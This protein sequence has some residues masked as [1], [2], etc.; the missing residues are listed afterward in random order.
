M[1]KTDGTSVSVCA[2]VY[3]GFVD[4]SA[5]VCIRDIS[6][7]GLSFYASES[8]VPDNQQITIAFT[9]A[10]D[11]KQYDV[12]VECAV[13]RVSS[14]NG[15]NVIGCRVVGDNRTYQL[16]EFMKR[17]AVERLGTG[18][19]AHFGERDKSGVA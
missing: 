6:A 5:E 11:D 1:Q 9:D 12:R 14:E 3:D 7:S 8:Y 16:Y 13:V 4:P 17:I 19:I 2:T 10:I 15:Q 18:L